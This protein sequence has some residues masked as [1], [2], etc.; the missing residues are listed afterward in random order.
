M[1]KEG[2]KGLLYASSVGVIPLF[3]HYKVANPIR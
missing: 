1:R 3:P 2:C